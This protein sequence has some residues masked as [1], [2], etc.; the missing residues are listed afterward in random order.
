MRIVFKK[1]KQKEL[2]VKYKIARGLSWRG[3]SRALNVDWRTFRFWRDGNLTLPKEIYLKLISDLPELDKFRKYILEER[4]DKWWRFTT[5]LLGWKAVEK[6]LKN[7]KSFREKWIKKC[8][9]GGI[10]A[11]SEGYIKGWD[12]G[13]R[14]VS[15]RRTRG[16]KGE[17]MFNEKEKAIAEFLV[18][19]NI[20]YAYEP[21]IKINSHVY[22]PDFSVGSKL[23]ERCGLWSKKYSY[24]LKKKLENYQDGW[25]GKI[26]LVT[27]QKMVKRL[28][29]MAP[30][31]NKFIVINE[32]G[33]E[34]LNKYLGS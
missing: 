31:S 5:P 2:F 9:L 19:N 1:G 17:L 18:E 7:N 25:K 28:R 3:V 22:F 21:M 24:E 27:S 30:S 34:E 20:R 15:R 32:N 10:K 13:F 33:L 16:P 12:V 6:K 26:I 14:K 8:R 11:V 29:R 23:I 4:E